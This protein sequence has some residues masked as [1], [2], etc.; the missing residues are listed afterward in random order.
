M[1]LNS[2]IID[3]SKTPD[4]Y[5]KAVLLEDALLKVLNDAQ[6]AKGAV[7]IAVGVEDFVRAFGGAS[8][9]VAY[10]TKCWMKECLGG[11]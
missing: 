2:G 9:L 6:P 5:D 1:H 4:L 11:R 8:L 10:R 3:L 7:K